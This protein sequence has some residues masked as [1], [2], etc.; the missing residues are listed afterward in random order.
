[1]KNS[2][3]RGWSVGAAG[4]ELA[5]KVNRCAMSVSQPTLPT[6]CSGKNNSNEPHSHF[7]ARGKGLPRAHGED[8]S[9]AATRF[10]S[11]RGPEL[12]PRSLSVPAGDAL[13]CS[14]ELLTQ[15][16]GQRGGTARA[17]LPDKPR[18]RKK[19]PAI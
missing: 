13:T 15:S 1:V 4:R 14:R 10:G 7:G 8:R 19:V 16:V 5:R 17:A 11:N 18:S 2:A 12:V 9:R 6:R 3:K